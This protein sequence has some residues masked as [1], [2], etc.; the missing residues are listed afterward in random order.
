[1]LYRKHETAHFWHIIQIVRT[2]LRIPN[3]L[4]GTLPLREHVH[5]FHNVLAQHLKRSLS[6]I[7]LGLGY[8]PRSS[9]KD[10]LHKIYNHTLVN[11]LMGLSK[12][13]SDSLAI[14]ATLG[15]LNLLV[16]A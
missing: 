16:E 12:T 15:W 8:R 7:G 1:M 14:S 2:Y 11:Y 6:N 4:K 9:S 13:R 10:Q 3:Q 5:N